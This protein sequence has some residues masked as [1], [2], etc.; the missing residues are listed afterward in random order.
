MR[1]RQRKPKRPPEDVT[2]L[3]TSCKLSDLDTDF[4]KTQNCN[5]RKV[6]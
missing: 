1:P 5:K 4:T 3:K 6:K 2:V